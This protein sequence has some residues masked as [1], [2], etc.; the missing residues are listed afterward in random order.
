MQ[1]SGGRLANR[2][3]EYIDSVG[4]LSRTPGRKA[5]G[6]EP[7]G[8]RPIQAFARSSAALAAAQRPSHYRRM[9]VPSDVPAGLGECFRSFAGGCP[10]G[11]R[12]SSNK[13]GCRS[14]ES[15]AR[16]CTKC[17]KQAASAASVALAL[18]RRTKRTF[19]SSRMS[20][21]ISVTR[22]A[23]SR[24]ARYRSRTRSVV[25]VGWDPHRAALGA[26][27]YVVFGLWSPCMQHR[28]RIQPGR[29][30]HRL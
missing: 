20:L 14:A 10:S 8:A 13:T 1:T 22:L 4:I 9:Q 17:H 21:R 27:G 24:A 26:T 3:A 7:L 11:A 19:G 23:G 6:W 18:F 16:T 15:S 2:R 29:L 5:G 25:A 28:L 12:A 30:A